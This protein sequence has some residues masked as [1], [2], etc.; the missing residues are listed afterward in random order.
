MFKRVTLGAWGVLLSVATFS[1][2][3]A[4]GAPARVHVGLETYVYGSTSV[5]GT[6]ST[7]TSSGASIAGP[8][9]VSNTSGFGVPSGVALPFGILLGDH[10]DLGARFGYTTRS[11]KAGV[12]A[13]APTQDESAV[14]VAPY[15][16]FLGGSH[17]NRIRFTVGVTAGLGSS[18][19]STTTPS[20]T[21]P[22]AQPSASE[23]FDATMST[24]QYGAFIGLRGF[25]NALGSIDPLVT[26]M[27]TSAT[28]EAG[29]NSVDMTGTTVLVGIGLSLWLGGTRSATSPVPPAAEVAVPTDTPTPAPRSVVAAN[30][31]PASYPP[32]KRTDRITLAMG[33][34]HAVTLIL[35]TASDTPEFSVILR[36]PGFANDSSCKSAVLHALRQADTAIE[37]S[38]AM[39]ST[40]AGRIQI[41]KA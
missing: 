11:Q 25:V 3:S 41:L 12:E 6:V 2:T 34:A 8:R 10:W 1:G 7:S 29:A 18:S 5:E 26:V 20:N 39:A 31:S 35:G 37:L 32:V 33:D 13:S 36:A 17:E 30:T 15:V 27:R 19:I 40:N 16:A 28:L 22:S 24:T 38:A 9:Y 4:A 23:T 21:N 14:A